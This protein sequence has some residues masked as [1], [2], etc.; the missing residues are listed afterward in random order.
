MGKIKLKKA[1]FSIIVLFLFCSSFVLA[2]PQFKVSGIMYDKQEPVAIV[3]GNFVKEGEKVDGAKVEKIAFN[4]VTFKYANETFVEYLWEIQEADGSQRK[5]SQKEIAEKKADELK[6]KQALPAVD[7]KILPESQKQTK[8]RVKIDDQK[9]KK[10]Q[11][12][13]RDDF[14]VK[15]TQTRSK[16]IFVFTE[17]NME[18]IAIIVIIG[19]VLLIAL[20]SKRKKI[21]VWQ[22]KNE[23][24]E[25]ELDGVDEGFCLNYIKLSYRRKL[26]R[27]LW[28]TMFLMLPVLLG[29]SKDFF[30]PEYMI[31]V[32]LFCTL[33]SFY[34][35]I[36]WKLEV[37]K[38]KSAYKFK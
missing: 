31:G 21:A 30:N 18:N 5:I 34:N 29:N 8:S 36:R 2:R 20:C 14:L 10:V 27:T 23:L 15:D 25:P 6:D 4:S 12:K 9:P 38:K 32:L 37:L 17:E 3:N 26:I 13:K 7:K 19:T 16:N 22:N 24:P 1:V 35:S 33:Q 28:I 11:I